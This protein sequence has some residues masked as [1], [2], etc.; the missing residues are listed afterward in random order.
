MNRAELMAEIDG[1]QS[2]IDTIHRE[3]EAP[4]MADFR[5]LKAREE[6][7]IEAGD[8]AEVEAIRPQKASTLGR[9]HAACRRKLPHEL[10]LRDLR[11]AIANIS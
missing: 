7:A 11:V 4:A 2:S 10:R 8:F 5:A 1:A 9:L 6:K 3:D